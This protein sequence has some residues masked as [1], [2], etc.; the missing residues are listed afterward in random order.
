M[1]PLALSIAFAC[2]SNVQNKMLRT[3]SSAPLD[4]NPPPQQEGEDARPTEAGETE[5]Q[6][7]PAPV[8][9]AST[10]P[11]P[12]PTPSPSSTP[13]TNAS[14]QP[15]QA[16][17]AFVPSGYVKTF[18]DEFDSLSLDTA[19]D[20]SGT[21]ATFHPNTQKCPGWGARFYPANSNKQ[22]W[23]DENYTKDGVK[24]GVKLHEITESGTLKLHGHKTPQ[25]KL[26]VAD[27]FQYVAAHINTQCSF[28]QK[29]GYFEGRMRFNFSKGHHWA[30]WTLPVQP[31]WPPELD[32]VERVGRENDFHN[33]FQN[34]HGEPTDE[35]ITVVPM[36]GDYK[37][38]V[39]YG[40][41]WTADEIVWY[42]NGKETRKIAN[43]IHEPFYIL[44]NLEIGG[45]WPGL[46]DATTTW[47]T[48]AEIDY[49]RV[50]KAPD[51]P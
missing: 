18:A 35:P 20:G 30:F 33:I 12:T 24:L 25:D 34:S 46:P 11:S 40:M 45:N 9:T 51:S 36:A 28:S 7:T 3:K 37:D 4:Q 42:V 1:M 14:P 22:I 47:P 48:T 10:T 19:G 39:T 21:W 41:K 8:P 44:I 6:S 23:L 2:D 32:I 50:Y 43:Y 16:D 17:S 5:S 26:A 27:N 31:K 38:W 49:V 15:A 29:Y 13:P